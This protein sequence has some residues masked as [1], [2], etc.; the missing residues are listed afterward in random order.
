MAG[1]QHSHAETLITSEAN[2]GYHVG[3]TFSHHQDRRALVGVEVEC[4]APFLIAL[5]ALFSSTAG[6]RVW[7]IP[8]PRR[9]SG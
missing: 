3:R 7:R 1:G 4:F 8:C 9:V 5:L 6:I 2:G